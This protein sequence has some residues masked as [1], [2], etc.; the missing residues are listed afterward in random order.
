MQ[1]N[2]CDKCHAKNGMAG[3]LI[4]GLCELCRPQRTQVTIEMDKVAADKLLAI[5]AD[6]IAW[7]RFAAY[8]QESGFPV[9][10]VKTE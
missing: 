8:M 6:L 4:N 3:N 10:G 1:Y 7:A 9:L 5:W 2:E